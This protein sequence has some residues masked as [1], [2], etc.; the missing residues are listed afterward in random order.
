MCVLHA[1][2]SDL[3]EKLGVSYFFVY[4][5]VKEIYYQPFVLGFEEFATIVYMGLHAFDN[6]FI[7]QDV[8][9]FL[10]TNNTIKNTNLITFDGNLRIDKFVWLDF[11]DIFYIFLFGTIYT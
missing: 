4:C 3:T 5:F 1:F 7:L 9:L 10:K 6:Y 8:F 2:F 11:F